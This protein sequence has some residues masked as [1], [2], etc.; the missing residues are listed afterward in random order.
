MGET[1][2]M[3]EQGVMKSEEEEQ[4]HGSGNLYSRLE[5]Y[6]TAG[7]YP[8]HMPGHKRSSRYQDWRLPFDRDITEIEGFDNLHHPTGILKDAQERL[9]ALYPVPESYFL[10]NGS[11]CGILAAISAACHP[12]GKIVMA[13]NC[14]KA[15]YHGVSLRDLDPV[16]VMP[17][18]ISGG[19]NGDII[20][21]EVER[22]LGENPDAQAVLLTSPTYDGVVSDISAIARICHAHE[23]PLLV[24]E[25]HGA[26]LPFSDY[27]PSSAIF[28]GA[29]I[30]IQS[31]HKTLP[32]LTQTAV[33]HRC[34]DRVLRDRLERFLGFY[35][36]SSP[37][38][39]LMES[40][41]RCVD[42]LRERGRED[43]ASF[44]CLL[45]RSRK[46]LSSNKYLRLY[47]P[48]GVFAYDPSKILLSAA[49][50]GYPGTFLAEWMRKDARLEPEMA[51]A[52]VCL[53][54]TSVGD[55]PEGFERL[56]ATVSR[57]E[58]EISKGRISVPLFDLDRC[59]E[60]MAGY[61]GGFLPR[62]VVRPA[63]AWEAESKWIPIGKAPGHVSASFLS[64][65]PPGIPLLVPGEEVTEKVV[66]FMERMGQLGLS[67][68]GLTREGESLGFCVQASGFW[69]RGQTG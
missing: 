55:R 5:D 45:D 56:L 36:T 27:F 31:F 3:Q 68:H 64:L 21:Q 52:Y 28:Q 61:G 54:L 33:L 23:I 8:F 50:L 46:V 12:G 47:V 15:A 38:Y 67:V 69:Q 62:K 7:Y 65:Y 41:D 32:A 51:S 53:C 20:P 44:T 10:V 18:Q 24:D 66:S 1:G 22:V 17:R 60:Q 40:I 30:V 34:S 29:D 57:L 63:L 16:Y 35:Q 48:E 37:S 43:F 26:H 11:S 42:Y 2:K 13:R 58:G 25:A 14:H 49:H 9:A 19:V 6:S 4:S 39:I 59:E